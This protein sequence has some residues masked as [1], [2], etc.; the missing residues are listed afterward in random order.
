[1]SS[2]KPIQFLNAVEGGEGYIQN[3]YNIIL[4]LASDI[5]KKE[6]LDLK[7]RWGKSTSDFLMLKLIF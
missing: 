3:K 6:S 1:M 7:K 2:K 4:R 5:T